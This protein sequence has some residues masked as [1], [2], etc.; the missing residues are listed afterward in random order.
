MVELMRRMKLEPNPR[1]EENFLIV[2]ALNE[3][4][5]GNVLEPS[6][7]WGDKY[8]TAFRE[9]MDIVDSLPWRDDMLKAGETIAKEIESGTADVDVCVL[10]RTASTNWPWTDAFGLPQMLRSLQTQSNQK[11]RAVLVPTAKDVNKEIMA[12]HILDTFDPRI[13]MAD[14]PAEILDELDSGHDSID[15]LDWA[16]EN[17]EKINSGCASASYFLVASSSSIYKPGAFDLVIKS[18]G[19]IVG[20]NFVSEE[21]MEATE[22]PELTWD[23]RCTRFVDGSTQLSRPMD[24]TSE[25]VNLGAAFINLRRWRSEGH[26]FRAHQDSTGGVAGFLQQLSTRP[27]G[28]AWSWVPARNTEGGGL[29]HGVTYTSCIKTGRMWLDIPGDAAGCYSLGSITA[30]FGWTLQPWDM[31]RFKENPFCL[32]MSQE[33]YEEYKKGSG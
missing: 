33:M 8:S 9:A 26:T 11:W 22:T 10:V 31:V 5:E 21:T 20:L 17:I 1:G 4:A 15:P 2:N 16:V 7:Q 3:W 14:V 6:I 32:R 23:Q 29:I 13:V 12:K 27:G 30:R 28:D 24:P 19:D 25:V 18:T